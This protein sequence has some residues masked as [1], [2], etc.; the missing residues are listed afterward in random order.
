V[1]LLPGD[2][3]C[4]YRARASGQFLGGLGADVAML[5]C[6]R[7]LAPV[8]KSQDKSTLRARLASIEPLERRNS[9]TALIEG[10]YDA[11]VLAE[12]RE[13]MSFPVGRVE[14]TLAGSAWLAGPEYSIADIDAFALLR[15][16]TDLVPELVN[17]RRTPRIADFLGR[18][19]ARKAVQQALAWSRSAKPQEAFVPGAGPSRGG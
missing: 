1:N 10:T 7:Y 5:G 14:Q 18:M 8:L 12:V 6:M 17:E 11:S 16:L 2:A 3:Y 15:P 13:R 19:H 4:H 9:W